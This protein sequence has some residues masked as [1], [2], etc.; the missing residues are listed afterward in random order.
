MDEGLEK[1]DIQMID[2]HMAVEERM[3]L[4]PKNRYT[5]VGEAFMRASTIGAA[6]P[7]CQKAL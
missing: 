7:K 6:R 2:C 5:N 3:D 1:W 4:R